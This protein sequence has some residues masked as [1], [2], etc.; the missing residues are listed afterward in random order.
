MRLL[1]NLLFEPKGMHNQNAAYS[2]KDTVMSGDGSKVYFAIQD[3]PA[4]IPL[5]DSNYWK[6]QIDLSGSKSAMDQ[7]LA[8]FGNYAKEVGTRVKGETAK[9]SGNPVTF[10][11]DAG[12]L[13]QPVTVL[14]PQQQGS[15]DPSPSNI[16]PI[17]GYDKLGLNHA[18][19]NLCPYVQHNEV[20]ALRLFAGRTYVVSIADSSA[21]DITLLLYNDGTGASYFRSVPINRVEGGRRYGAFT[22]DRDTTHIKFTWGA[23][24]A[25]I[26]PQIEESLVVTP[27]E[28]Y[29]GK[30]HTVQIGQTVYG[31]RYEWL[32]GKGVIEW[33]T[34]ILDGSEEWIDSAALG[35]KVIF[36]PGSELP[37]TGV[38]AIAYM[39]HFKRSE[40]LVLG[41]MQ[42]NE[43]TFA[44]ANMSDSSTLCIRTD[45]SVDELR[46]YLAG[47]KAAGTPVQ[48]TRKLATPVEI[49]P[50]TPHIIS[51]A[52][53]EQTNTLYGDGR[54]DVE[55]VKPLH[56]SIGGGSGG[57]SALAP[58]QS[59]NGKT[60]DV[61][62]TASDVG[63]LPVETEIP[64]PY[65]L[66]TA[67]AE[68]KGG[69]KVGEGL[70]M[71]GDVLGVVPEPELE[72]IET[73]VCDGTYGNVSRSNLS[74]KRVVLYIHTQAATAAASI[75]IEVR[76]G[77]EM[78]GYTWIGNGINTAERWMYAN[79]VS[80]GKQ[81]A[82]IEA[83]GPSTSKH[84][85]NGLSRTP[86]RYDGDTPITRVNIYASGGVM[87]PNDSTI[88]IWG[89]RA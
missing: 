48:F 79:A 6:L 40:T 12:S 59:V 9:A 8:S 24:P 76:N 49:G 77:K 53:P 23:T 62:L 25:L 80:G 75:G 56:V 27:Y 61:Q 14:E 13:L 5:N 4:G 83:T 11:P 2:I 68:V 45:M 1:T 28:P 67:S 81:E 74:L 26:E 15:G 55:Y 34:D 41:A 86:S 33:V 17:I 58:V 44:N 84:T 65:T 39:S 88:E 72:F 30:L 66:P 42:L 46:A 69:V 29:Q 71:D 36:T 32:T 22:L 16:R 57:G 64:K 60:G 3:V 37:A 51:A 47:Q 87:L 21:S 73:I 78:F 35:L 19:K 70:Q 31:F 52:D 85:S 38:N 20:V 54:I 43:F 7:A 89:V 18:G 10:L 82:Y 50:F 63:A